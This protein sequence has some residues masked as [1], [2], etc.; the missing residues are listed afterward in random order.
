MNQYIL[1]VLVKTVYPNT[2]TV[3]AIDIDEEENDENA[4]GVSRDILIVASPYEYGC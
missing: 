1:T 3:F 4:L 2:G